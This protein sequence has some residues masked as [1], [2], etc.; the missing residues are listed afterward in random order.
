M[1][2]IV[3]TSY[4]NT[5]EYTEPVAWL[6]RIRFYTGILEALAKDHEV[7]SIERI[8]YEG[9]LQQNKVHYHFINLRKKKGIV[10]AS[11]AQD[12]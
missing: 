3:S 10:P 7:T 2:K 9:S 1:M 4:S 8:R 11:H 6:K 5:P 12:D